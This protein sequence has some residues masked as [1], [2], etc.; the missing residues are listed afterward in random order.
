VLTW[1]GF[2]PPYDR[3]CPDADAYS[4]WWPRDFDRVA[5]WYELVETVVLFD[6]QKYMD[7]GVSSGWRATI[8][9]H[10]WGHNL[11][12]EDH[13]EGTVCDLGLLMGRGPHDLS[14]SPCM[15]SPSPQEADSV[16]QFYGYWGPADPDQD[17]FSNDRENWVGTDPRDNCSDIWFDA[18][19]PLD[20]DNDRD[21]DAG[22]DVI[23]YS[24]RMNAK[25]GSP[26]WWQRLD[27]NGD[28]KLNAGGDVIKYSGKIGN[29]CT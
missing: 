5:T 7:G 26:L 27:L 23:N 21:I 3:A 2:E 14:G 24:G 1:E 15:S 4:C 16:A 28:G 29:R 22:G 9:A 18:A 19:W 6:N 17:G 12:L 25:P 11:G 10:E 20:I 8:S 13:A